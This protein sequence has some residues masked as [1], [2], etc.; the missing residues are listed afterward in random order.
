M[1]ELTWINQEVVLEVHADQLAEHGGQDGPRDRG[2]LESALNRSCHL[3]AYSSP[4]PDPIAPASSL[5][6]G[7]A[8]NHPFLDGNKRTAWVLCRTFPRVNGADIVVEQTE[9]VA[10]VL[11]LAAGEL[12][13]EDSAAWLRDH[14]S[15]QA[16]H[17]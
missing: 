5:A 8:R 10:T 4:K 16:P 6:F 11:A 7:V 1:T 2:L 13:E 14:A 3:W 9:I 15:G 12:S 17:G